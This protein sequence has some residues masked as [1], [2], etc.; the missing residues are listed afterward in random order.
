MEHEED[1]A[2][3]ISDIDPPVFVDPDLIRMHPQ[4]IARTLRG[5]NADGRRICE[6]KWFGSEDVRVGSDLKVEERHFVPYRIGITGRRAL[7]P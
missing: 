6:L 3:V 7:K 1:E 4:Q 5:L 2:G